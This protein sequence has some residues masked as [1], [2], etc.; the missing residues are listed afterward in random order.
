[1]ADKRRFLLVFRPESDKIGIL[2]YPPGVLN[3]VLVIHSIAMPSD[4]EKIVTSL[5]RTHDGVFILS[6]DLQLNGIHVAPGEIYIYDGTI[7]FV[8]QVKGESIH[9]KA[10][11][12]GLVL[13]TG[14]Q[15]PQS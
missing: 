10:C 9:V 6:P 2:S 8:Y 11:V 12:S 15:E 3:R 13:P 1:M 14:Q 5:A 7:I 4:I